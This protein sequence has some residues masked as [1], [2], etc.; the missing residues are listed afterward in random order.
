MSKL[1]AI[2]AHEIERGEDSRFATVKIGPRKDLETG[3]DIWFTLRI[4]RVDPG[5]LMMQGV[6]AILSAIPDADPNSKRKPRPLSDAQ[7]RKLTHQCHGIVCASVVAEWDEETQTWDPLTLDPVRHD[8]SNR[9]LALDWFLAHELLQLSDAI[10]K[11]QT[12]KEVGAMLATLFQG[13]RTVFKAI[14][15][16]AVLSLGSLYNPDA[17]VPGADRNQRSSPESGDEGGTEADP[18]GG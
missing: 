15:D 1:S 7:I 9:V 5:A 8:P 17:V 6:P 13:A 12:G 3:E 11:L 2:A 4:K 16:G 14:L 18:D 10:I